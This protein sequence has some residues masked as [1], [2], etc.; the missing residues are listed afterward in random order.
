MRVPLIALVAL[1][2][3]AAQERPRPPVVALRNATLALDASTTIEKATLVLRGGLVEAAG[4]D[5]KIPADAEIIDA[6]G[7][8]V[9]PG[10]V[11]GLTSSGLGDTKRSPEERK[12][13][14][15]TPVDFVADSL[16]GMESANRKGI[17]PELRS[18][19]MLTFGEDDLKKHQKGGFAALH[20]AA[21][22][23]YLAGVGAV[24]SM[25]GGTR[26]EIIVSSR[27]GMAGSYRAYG[28]GYPSTPMGIL[29]HLRQV[30]LD[31]R[32]LREQVI[33][34]EKDPK[35]R[36][37]PPSDRSLESI[38]PLFDREIPLFMEANTELEIERAL[39]LAAEFKFDVVI[40]GGREAGLAA[41]R[42]KETG[43]RVILGLKFPR[44]PKR[45]KK[46]PSAPLKEGEYEEL[47]KPKKQYDDEKREWERRVRAAITLQAKGVP[48]AFST[49]GLDEPAAAL[50]QI[51]KL[52]SRGL[53]R[54]AALRALTESPAA[55]LKAEAAYGKLAPGR[56]ANVTVLTAPLGSPETR[57]RFVFADGRKFDLEP[58]GK[59]E[60]AV[61]MDLTGM[62]TLTAEKS[63]AG[64]LTIKAE[65]T[66]KDRDLAGTLSSSS[67]GGGTITFGRVTGKSFSFSARIKVDG[68]ETELEVRGEKKDE[69]LEGKLSGPFGDDVAWKGKKGP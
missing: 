45:P 10:F 35:G 1:F 32:R 6:T 47:P 33:A 26:R 9:Y 4:V 30:F 62:W 48:F 55:F 14:E 20:V 69:G 64:P 39:G 12:K 28:D 34:Y 23:E 67:F 18:A 61:E 59:A 60:A 46:G 25:N 8:Y 54:D 63:D 16:G 5:A 19:D 52:V 15:A 56:P 43:T 37:R 2:L 29:A 40:T 27:T 41:D 31:S 50:K 44:E 21:S 3:I 17:R 22:E 65:L 7:L 68:E 11:D 38:W 53:P 42:L 24:V 51:A 57:V 49:A 36:T 13:A 66:Q 58:A